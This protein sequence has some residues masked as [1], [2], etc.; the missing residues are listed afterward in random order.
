MPAINK[1]TLDRWLNA[2]SDPRVQAEAISF[3][4]EKIDTYE[5]FGYYNYD[6]KDIYEECKKECTPIYSISSIRRWWTIF[7]DWGEL[8]YIVKLKQNKWKKQLGN[9]SANASI[10]YSE[11]MQLKN[12]VDENPN[13]YL[14]EIALKFAVKTGKYLAY[15]TISVI[16]RTKLNY[17]MQVLSQVAIQRCIEEENRENESVEM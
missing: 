4:A 8:P 1:Q 6:M 2:H 5:A 13:L 12:I 7:L 17:S 9:M 3:I 15:N 11:L 10:T 16:L 14:D